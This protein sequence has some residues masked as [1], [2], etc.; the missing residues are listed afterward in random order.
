ML[1]VA[2]LWIAAAA[3]EA[4]ELS[5]IEER[6]VLGCTSGLNQRDGSADWGKVIIVISAVVD[7]FCC[8]CVCA[9]CCAW[10]CKC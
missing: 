10:V 4:G 6:A 1:K 5:W 7:G 2:E 8:Q 3:V 9:G